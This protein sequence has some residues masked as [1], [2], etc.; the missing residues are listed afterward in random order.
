MI[1]LALVVSWCFVADV[2]KYCTVRPCI[3]DNQK[4][5]CLYSRLY[6]RS[7]MATKNTFCVLRIEEKI[8]LWCKR[9]WEVAK[10]IRKESREMH[11]FVNILFVCPVYFLSHFLLLLAT[12]L[13]A[14]ALTSLVF[15]AE[16]NLVKVAGDLLAG[17][18]ETPS[19]TMLWFLLYMLHYPHIQERC[20]Q[21]R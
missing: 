17:G 21:V 6:V 11:C 2:C 12:W 14:L 18:S 16:E 5:A 7:M 15:C 4:D 8:F 13:P 9:V 19:T 20:Y 3:S 1:P 10:K